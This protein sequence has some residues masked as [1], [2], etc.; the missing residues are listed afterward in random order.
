M[1]YTLDSVEHAKQALINKTKLKVKDAKPVFVE[2]LRDLVFV[3]NKYY[4][5]VLT[6]GSNIDAGV[7]S[8][9]GNDVISIAGDSQA[10]QL[11]QALSIKRFLDPYSMTSRAYYYETYS[12]YVYQG[13]FR[14]FEIVMG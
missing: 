5:G 14:G 13:C 2:D 4:F 1:N 9:G 3:E 10:I 8:F 12:G 7:L 11:F 6:L